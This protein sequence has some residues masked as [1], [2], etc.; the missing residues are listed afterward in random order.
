MGLNVGVAHELALRHGRAGPASCLLCSGAD[1]GEMPSSP[2]SSL[3][4][5]DR[6]ERWPQVM[7]VG[8]L[9]LSLTSF[10]TQEHGPCT[11]PRQRVELALAAAADEPGL[12]V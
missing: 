8:E 6:W 7:R 3:T 9:S 10:Y 11:S 5:N 1:E 4:I 12:R 2:P